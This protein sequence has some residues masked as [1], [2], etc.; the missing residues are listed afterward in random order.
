MIG[1][2]TR[3]RFH[4]LLVPIV[5]T[6]AFGVLS[7]AGPAQAASMINKFGLGGVAISGYD[8]VGYFTMGRAVKGSKQF[9][10]D[11][12]GATWRFAN[13]EHRDMFATDPAKYAPQYGGYCSAGVADGNLSPIDPK[14][15][16]IVDGKLYLIYSKALLA[17]WEQDLPT[18]IARADVNWPRMEANLTQ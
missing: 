13:A 16:R 2:F 15:W 4:R 7:V 14:A 5:L 17:R 18:E 8:P 6:F 10:Y 12:L 11:W 3:R 9:T 1:N